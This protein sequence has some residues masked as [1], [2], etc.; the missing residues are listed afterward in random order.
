MMV[1][2][3]VL[4][5]LAPIGMMVGAVGAL[6]GRPGVFV[7]GFGAAAVFAGVGIPLMVI[8]GR[9]EAGPTARLAPWFAPRT[10]GLGLELRL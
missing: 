2:G 9:R 4:T 5:S 1:S 3:I 6:G 8:G 7:G 10:A